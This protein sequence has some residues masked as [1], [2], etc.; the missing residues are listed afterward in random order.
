MSMT[1]TP[2]IFVNFCFVI[3]KGSEWE[4]N[5]RLELRIAHFSLRN[6]KVLSSFEI[7]YLTNIIIRTQTSHS[8]VSLMR[9]HVVEDVELFNY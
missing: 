3:K 1:D 9:T 7:V 5:H 6:N 8:I 2:H 4:K